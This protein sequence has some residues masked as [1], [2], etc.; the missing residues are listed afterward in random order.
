MKELLAQG[1]AR[2][3]LTPPPAAAEQMETYARLLLEQNKVMNLTAITD[4]EQVA[5]LH[6]L[7]SAALLGCAG[8][9]SGRT[10]IDVGTGAGFPGMALKLLCPEL[11]LTLLDSLAKRLDWLAAVC[12]RLGLEDVEIVHARAEE[13]GLKPGFRDHFDFA[14]ARAVA[15][16]RVLCELCL[17]FVRVGGRFL[18]MK[19]AD[20]QEEL[21]AA[22][23]AIQTL[24][25]RRLEDYTYTIPGTD[26]IRR[27][28]VIEK[29]APTPKPYP[30]R[31]AKIQKA[32]L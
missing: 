24:G 11:K 14:T 29:T 12:S 3:G 6:F 16:L 13:Q 18:A 28:A 19:A 23:T 10:L 26:V 2:L 15:D 1:L 21:D 25:G 22:R 7:D 31:W 4:P 9:L 30:R 32:P 17:P 8:D 20:S 27:V 5:R